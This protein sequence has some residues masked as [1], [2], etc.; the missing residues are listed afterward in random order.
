M[1]NITGL[2]NRRTR[3][4][5][6][7]TATTFPLSQTLF[8]LVTYPLH[9]TGGAGRFAGATGDMN[10]IGEV[11]LSAGTVFLQRTSVL[12]GTGLGLIQLS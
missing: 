12:R 7:G 10:A 5:D 6:T 8:A 3:S 1:S 4:F 11:D 2:P 9:L